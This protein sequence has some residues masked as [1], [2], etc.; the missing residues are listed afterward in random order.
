[1]KTDP[2]VIA[3]QNNVEAKRAQ[4]MHSTK[5]AIGE[6]KRRLA[7]D[8]VADQVWEATKNKAERIA[9]EATVAARNRPWLVGGA[10]AAATLFMA[11]KPVSRLASNAYQRVTSDHDEKAARLADEKLEMSAPESPVAVARMA[12]RVT[13]KQEKRKVEKVK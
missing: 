11:R 5:L 4:L 8:L 13:P 10:I 6:A 7:P 12:K 9:Q 1:M 2:R 3:A